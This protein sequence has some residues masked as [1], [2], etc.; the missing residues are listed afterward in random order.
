MTAASRNN[1]ER[2]RARVLIALSLF[3]I[4]VVTAVAGLSFISGILIAVTFLLLSGGYTGAVLIGM[5]ILSSKSCLNCGGKY[6]ARA[7]NPSVFGHGC[8]KCHHV[9]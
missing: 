1:L 9:G 7:F 4:F 6:F 5:A 8:A 2:L 3:P